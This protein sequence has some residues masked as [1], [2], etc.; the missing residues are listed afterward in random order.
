MEM[1]L[2][3]FEGLLELELHH[4]RQ[5]SDHDEFSGQLFVQC[6]TSLRDLEDVKVRWL[7]HFAH[8][9]HPDADFRTKVSDFLQEP[10]EFKNGNLVLNR[11]FR[12][13]IGHCVI[14]KKIMPRLSFKMV[15]PMGIHIS[16]TVQ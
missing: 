7:P 4:L 13:P 10:F 8:E 1:G 15:S 5:V 9:P 12:D 6:H 16:N 2:I 11:H 3:L 14:S